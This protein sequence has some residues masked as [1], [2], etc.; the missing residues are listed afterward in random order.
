MFPQYYELVFQLTLFAVP[1]P[2][3]GI[4]NGGSTNFGK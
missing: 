2:W 4:C 3:S 1:M